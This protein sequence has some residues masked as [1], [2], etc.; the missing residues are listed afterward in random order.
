MKFN[1]LKY[2][3]RFVTGLKNAIDTNTGEAVAGNPGSGCRKTGIN[4]SRLV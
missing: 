2:K 4:Y 1:M 3:G